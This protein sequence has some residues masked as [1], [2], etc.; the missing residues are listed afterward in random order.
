MFGSPPHSMDEL[1]DAIAGGLPRDVVPALAA[2]AAPDR[3]DLRRK[4]AALVVSPATYKREGRLSPAAGER[5][6]R[7]ARVTAL[8][9]EVLGDPD[10]ARA[11]LTEPHPLLGRRSPIETAATDLGARAVERILHNIAHGLPA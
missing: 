3:D 10:E 1:S 4:V 6:E 5:A 2:E 9:H 8:A 7:L 11:R